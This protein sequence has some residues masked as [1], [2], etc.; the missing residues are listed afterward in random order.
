MAAS[1]I[2]WWRGNLAK[3]ESGESNGLLLTL[4]RREKVGT[5]NLNWDSRHRP[6]RPP[7]LM[8]CCHAE[9]IR[10]ESQKSWNRVRTYAH[11]PLINF[12]SFLNNQNRFNRLRSTGRSV[13][14]RE[15]TLYA[16]DHDNCDNKA[17]FVALMAL[18]WSHCKVEW[19]MIAVDQRIL[20]LTN[21]LTS[22]GRSVTAENANLLFF[23]KPGALSDWNFHF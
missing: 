4:M 17:V 9:R 13:R 19:N 14:E 10:P 3:W 22:R 6:N 16:H 7:G 23:L 15:F 5:E 12:H 20:L 21:R 8:W 1:R 2:R 18:L 11:S